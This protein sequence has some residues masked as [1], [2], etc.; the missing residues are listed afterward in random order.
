MPARSML[1][2]GL[3]KRA[4]IIFGVAL[5]LLAAGCLA[6]PRPVVNQPNT[7]P[8]QENTTQLANPASKFC[9]ENGYS[10]D[11]RKAADG[12]ETGYCVF[13]NGRECEE[14]A[15][16]R[17]ECNESGIAD[18]NL[19]KEGEFCGGYAGILCEPGLG[20][21]L[22]SN[23]PD[24]GGRCT[25]PVQ[26]NEYV[27]CAGK[28]ADVCPALYEPVCGR[29]GATPSAY[30]YQDYS[31]ACVACSRSSPAAGYYSGTCTENKL[32]Q[33]GKLL[34]VLY[35]CALNRPETCANVTD[36]VCGR[37]VDPTSSLSYFRDYDNPCT[38]CSKGSNAIAYYVG[39]CEDR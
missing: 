19:A 1:L 30:D 34:S 6:P 14:W 3:M 38:A 37:A 25:K 13:A 11:I 32:T 8:P 7:T 9:I 24:A 36:P 28:S 21:I 26:Q 23:Y 16:F 2:G 12:S 27:E 18:K 10:L 22:D 39:K 5:V 17:G 15:Y 33:K 29:A 35:T 20:C 31:N 4:L